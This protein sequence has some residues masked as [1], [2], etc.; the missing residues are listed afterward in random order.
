MH[1]LS[2]QW[3]AQT[4]ARF[5]KQ[6]PFRYLKNGFITYKLS[7]RFSLRLFRLAKQLSFRN[8]ENISAR[9]LAV[10]TKQLLDILQ[11]SFGPL[12]LLI[13]RVRT[14]PRKNTDVFTSIFRHQ[15]YN[16]LTHNLVQ[17]SM[18]LDLAFWSNRK[19]LKN[20]YSAWKTRTYFT[21]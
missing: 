8:L 4:L 14:P 18:I 11:R 12:G 10:L 5:E 7:N 17:K 21:V 19:W 3:F 13:L 2:K 9:C 16:L 20:A 6:L 1:E 15:K